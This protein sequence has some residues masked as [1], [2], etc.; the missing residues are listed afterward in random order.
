MTDEFLELLWVLEHTLAMYPQLD[1]LLEAI[2]AGPIFTADELSY[3]SEAE[4]KPPQRR[5]SER[6]GRF[7]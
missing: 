2:V 4:R 6:Q 5:D 1:D 3:P 7:L